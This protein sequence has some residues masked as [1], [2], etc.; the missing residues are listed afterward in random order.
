M[1]LRR[2][3][4]LAAAGALVLGACSGDD[5]DDLSAGET[6]SPSSAAD[7]TTSTSSAGESTTTTAPGCPV[8]G[9]TDF[10]EARSGTDAAG[11]A[12]PGALNGVAVETSDDGCVDRVEFAFRDA[13]PGYLVDYQP[14][15]FTQ[16][17]S[18]EA[19]Q[20]DGTQYVVV[21]FEPAHTFDFETGEEIYT[22]PREVK[23]E[24]TRFVR[25]VQNTGDF[26]AV[27]TWV[28]GV[29]ERAPVAV[30][31]EGPRLV[32]SLG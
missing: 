30:S 26:E 13:V 19:V 1:P 2:L 9:D 25:E 29:S 31:T 22:G 17:G 21:R 4:I 23:P 18:G 11:G 14:G 7:A 10:E 6:T 24:G 8:A 12:A 20:V 32:V 5:N 16:D 15:P 28:I 3:A 27:V